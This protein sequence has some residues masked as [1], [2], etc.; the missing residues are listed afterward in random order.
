MSAPKTRKRQKK[1]QPIRPDT[2]VIDVRSHNILGIDE[3]I[4]EILQRDINNIGV[5][6]A[7]L[8]SLT[9]RKRNDISTT[10]RIATLRNKILD[11]ESCSSYWL[12]VIRT[13]KI[14][15]E[16]RLI[17]TEMPRK[18]FGAV[19]QQNDATSLRREWCVQEFLKIARE[20]IRLQNYSPGAIRQEKVCGMCS[21]VNF[22]ESMVDVCLFVCMDCGAETQF[23]D[24]SPTYGDSDRVNMAAKY[25]YTRKGHITDAMKKFQGVQTINPA[26]QNAIKIVRQEMKKQ[27]L[28]AE[29]N[30]LRSVSK[31]HIYEFLKEQKLSACYE[32]LNLIFQTITGVPCPNISVYEKEIME[33]FEAL[34]RVYPA[35]KNP[36]RTNSLTVNYKLYKLLQRR[37]FLCRKDDFYILKTPQKQREHDEVMKRA[38][39]VL[40]WEWIPT[41]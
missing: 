29:Q 36:E 9:R 32:D 19:S 12:Y 35:I 33:D 41:F 3:K 39:D 14:L 6:A 38:W 4:K 22:V 7:E 34:E 5:Y 13:E 10:T 24:D 26:L 25:T 2:D 30:Q 16:Y 17:S 23:E 27:N 28:V 18:V 40:G 21:G 37:G 15:E 31:D 20:Y 11:A 8:R 1:I